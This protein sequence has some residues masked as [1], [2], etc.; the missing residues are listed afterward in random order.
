MGYKMKKPS[1]TKGTTAH[2]LAL[3]KAMDKT[4]LPDGRPGSSALQKRDVGT[5]GDDSPVKKSSPVKALPVVPILGRLAWMGARKVVPKI[6]RKILK[7]IGK[8]QI[9]N[10]TLEL[11]ADVVTTGV[12]GKGGVEGIKK[13]DKIKQNERDIKNL[14]NLNQMRVARRDNTKKT[15]W[16]DPNIKFY[17]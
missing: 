14:K 15:N 7:K 3:N 2:K 5:W 8:K 10:P 11:G 12:I 16:P 6:T 17:K 9:T 4:S 13:A 1:I